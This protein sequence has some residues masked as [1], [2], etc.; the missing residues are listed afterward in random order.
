MPKVVP[1]IQRVKFSKNLWNVAWSSIAA[2][3]RF[4]STAI[5]RAPPNAEEGQEYEVYRS[6]STGDKVL[7]HTIQNIRAILEENITV[8]D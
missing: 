4:P 5:Y 8:G 1:E 3:F 7:E 2:L 6:A